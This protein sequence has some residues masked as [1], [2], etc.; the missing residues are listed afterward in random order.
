MLSLSEPHLT[1]A[2]KCLESLEL[3]N[4]AEHCNCG[5]LKSEMIRDHH[6]VG[7]QDLA[8]SERLQLDRQFYNQ[9]NAKYKIPDPKP[10]M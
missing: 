6:V 9:W 2:A 10:C 4:L 5:D 1:T 7:I 8:L 3:Y